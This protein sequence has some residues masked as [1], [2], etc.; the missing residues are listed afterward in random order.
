MAD[1]SKITLPSGTEYNIKDAYAR[2]QIAA[3]VG[4]DAVIFV[5]VSTTELTDGGNEI[6]TVSGEQKTPGPG[7]L[8]F[9]GT[10]EFIYG[11]DNKWHALG[12]LESLGD[13]AYQDTASS[14]YTPQGTVAAPTLTVTTTNTTVNSITDVGTLPTCTLPELTTSVVNENLTLSWAA[15]SF[16]AGT[17]PTKGSNTTVATGIDTATAT[18]PTFIGTQ[19][20][21]TVS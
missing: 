15:G 11:N 6:P 21:I 19:A 3:L 2:Q 17:L 5:G 4:G 16:S 13:L 8:Y 18:A 10:Q 20:T 1:I 14:S 12:S 9:Y 7:Q